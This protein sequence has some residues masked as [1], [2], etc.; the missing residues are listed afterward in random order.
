MNEAIIRQTFLNKCTTFVVFNLTARFERD[1]AWPIISMYT[2]DPFTKT[3]ILHK[4]IELIRW[5]PIDSSIALLE[6]HT[7]LKD[8]GPSVN[9]VNWSLDLQL[10]NQESIKL[11]P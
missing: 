5:F 4:T 3:I 9:K 11:P 6:M 2:S 8:L 7:E 10:S 1:L